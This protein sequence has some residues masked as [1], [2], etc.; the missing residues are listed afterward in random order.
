MDAL[1]RECRAKGGFFGILRESNVYRMR[2]IPPRQRRRMM[3]LLVALLVLL[4][5]INVA[6][7][8]SLS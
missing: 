4:Y 1:N 7:G 3:L 6:V 2:C 8:D 5:L